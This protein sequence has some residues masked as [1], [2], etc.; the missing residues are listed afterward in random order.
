MLSSGKIGNERSC[1]Q[2]LFFGSI[3]PIFGALGAGA[4]AAFG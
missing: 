1:G 2:F 3:L 4:L